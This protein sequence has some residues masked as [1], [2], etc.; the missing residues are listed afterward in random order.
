MRRRRK[1]KA[2]AMDDDAMERVKKR[3]DILDLVSKPIKKKKKKGKKKK[4]D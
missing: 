1:T 2:G 3:Q 4:G